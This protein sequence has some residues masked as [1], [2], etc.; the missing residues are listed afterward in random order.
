LAAHDP[1]RTL[2][3]HPAVSDTGIGA[4]GTHVLSIAAGN[5]R[6]GGPEGVAPEA[7]LLFVHLG[8]PGWDRAGPLGDSSNLL[9]AFDFMVEMAG[10]R[11]LAINMSLGRHGGPHDGS[12]LVELAIDWLLTARPGL[13]I[14]QSAGNYFGRDVHIAGRLRGDTSV[15]LP[16]HVD[17]GDTS[18][19]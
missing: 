19:N 8:V 11:P 5:G 18:P 12:T 6:S 14:V 2:D 10:D 13:A 15:T 4:H 7:S 1:Y 3:Y 17:P 9:E 16:F